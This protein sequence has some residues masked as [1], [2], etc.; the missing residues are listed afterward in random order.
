[1]IGDNLACARL[2]N[3]KRKRL[4]P[5]GSSSMTLG[6]AEKNSSKKRRNAGSSLQ[7]Q[8]ST[9]V[10]RIS[11]R[12][13][14][15]TP[16]PL[17][18]WTGFQMGTTPPSSRRQG[19][20]SSGKSYATSTPSKPQDASTASKTQGTKMK[21]KEEKKEKSTVKETE[22]LENSK[23]GIVSSSRRKSA[24]SVRSYMACFIEQRKRI[25]LASVEELISPSKKP[26]SIQTIQSACE[27]SSKAVDNEK[28]T[29]STNDSNC[30]NQVSGFEDEDSTGDLSKLD[31]PLFSYEK[32]VDADLTCTPER[33]EDISESLEV[34]FSGEVEIPLDV[35]VPQNIDGEVRDGTGR[36]PNRDS[37]VYLEGKDIDQ[38]GDKI[39]RTASG[40]S[41]TDACNNSEKGFDSGDN[42][43]A[44]GCEKLLSKEESSR[45]V[46]YW[47]PA[48]IS[49]VQLE[50]YCE[51]LLSNAVLLCSSSKSVP[52][53]A[54]QDI[55]I[56]AH[57]CCNHP[58][59]MDPNL[60][61]LLSRYVQ[62]TEYL[63]VGIKA[64]GKL[65]LLD[66]LLHKLKKQKMRVLILFQSIKGCLDSTGDILD[67]YVRQRFGE[68]SYERVDGGIVSSRI[69]AAL[70]KFNQ[71]DQ[72]R[73][74]FLLENRACHHQIVLS[75]IDVVIIFD[76]DWNPLNDLRNLQKIS[77]KSALEPVKVF[78]L[79]TSFTVEE[80]ALVCAKH[81][82]TWDGKLLSVSSSTSQMLLMWG[83]SYLMKKLE[84]FHNSSNTYIS[85]SDQRLTEN[86]AQGFLNLLHFGK[87]KSV[88]SICLITKARGSL[89]GYG[90]D[91]LL[92]G[93]SMLQFEPKD[94]PHIFWSR[95]LD[96]KDP[97]WKYVCVSSKR[98]RKRVKL[99]DQSKDDSGNAQKKQRRM[100]STKNPGP[101]QG[102][103]ANKEGLKVADFASFPRNDCTASPETG[104]LQKDD[105][106]KFIDAQKSLHLMLKQE[107]STLSEVLELS[108]W[109][110]ASLLKEKM[111]YKESVELS[112][113][114]LGY[115]CTKEEED[116]LHMRMRDLKKSF[117]ATL[118]SSELIDSSKSPE[119]LTK[120]LKANHPSSK[121]LRPSRISV[122]INAERNG[123]PSSV[124][125]TSSEAFSPKARNVNRPNS[126]SDNPD[127]TESQEPP[128][129]PKANGMSQDY[130]A[131]KA[132]L[133]K[134]YRMEVAIVQQHHIGSKQTEKL[135]IMKWKHAKKLKELKLAHLTTENHIR[136]GTK[137]FSVP[138]DSGVNANDDENGDSEGT[139]STAR[140]PG[141]TN[142]SEGASLHPEA[143]NRTVVSRATSVIAECAQTELLGCTGS[144]RNHK[145]DVHYGNICPGE[146]AFDKEMLGEVEKEML[147]GASSLCSMQHTKSI[148]PDDLPLPRASIDGDSRDQEQQV[149]LLP[150][151]DEAPNPCHF[152]SSDMEGRVGL[153]PELQNTM[154]RREL[155]EP[156]S[157]NGKQ[158]DHAVAQAEHVVQPQVSGDVSLPNAL[159]DGSQP[160]A[161]LSSDALVSSGDPGHSFSGQRHLPSQT[162]VHGSEGIPF[163]WKFDPLKIELEKIRKEEQ[164]ADQ[165][166]NNLTERIK[167]QRDREIQEAVAQICMRFDCKVKEAE[168]EYTLKKNE[169]DLN[170][171][172]A[173][174]NKILARDFG[175]TWDDVQSSS[176]LRTPTGESPDLD[177]QFALS[178]LAH[179][180]QNQS[181]GSG[182]HDLP[183]STY[184]AGTA[185]LSHS[186]SNSHNSFPATRPINPVLQFSSSV[187]SMSSNSMVPPTWAG[188]AIRVQLSHAPAPPLLQFQTT[189]TSWANLT[190]AAAK[191]H[192]PGTSVSGCDNFFV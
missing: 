63:D 191:S 96:G 30:D 178:L 57:K 180:P 102:A 35:N 78:R 81:G 168:T 174:I 42:N 32:R 146:G 71:M 189:A 23:M 133:E 13:T 128:L 87:E 148:P 11:K 121:P 80:K 110:S 72:G 83:A 48:Q 29:Q 64:S 120:V 65:V 100:S 26:D 97:C 165:A 5:L 84:E 10:A 25:N 15:R 6:S 70:N 73:F 41:E 157:W 59:I 54:L 111:D 2:E 45:F 115:S 106:R 82:S 58:Y 28:S 182:T 118:E 34:P 92:C 158:S 173:Y 181:V 86:V 112:K 17:K 136:H 142:F 126:L 8:P 184:R 188:N 150:S 88:T 21:R 37:Q 166:Y 1:M 163:Y 171:N 117:L 141:S 170:M 61:S 154:Q 151:E 176:F 187:V 113:R 66:M 27:F 192:Q 85:K 62:P 125:G 91:N 20:T 185:T 104:I 68:D 114:I 55:L 99:N 105:R 94:L 137:S 144:T 52:T 139:S 16:R 135:E 53:A 36:D 14:K 159:L 56:N 109:S 155:K 44:G 60:P 160:I 116:Y 149:N 98:N 75:S 134:A 89:T 101:M 69:L 179:D 183:P 108:C 47:V 156:D 43:Q 177:P 51:M 103:V 9:S 129:E 145:V 49:N 122:V 67:D 186:P 18:R 24:I 22:S 38:P 143:E 190:R 131:R 33:G 124:A 147:P 39:L 95:L 132:S 153:H 130:D 164:H 40:E 79:Y 140:A 162:Y 7:K 19:E 161:H 12:L 169:L 172:R 127:E 152:T 167:S 107:I 175:R 90:T 138:G 4:R 76:S 50:Q 31:E 123:A 3:S 93:E 46:E 77:L 74:V 119:L